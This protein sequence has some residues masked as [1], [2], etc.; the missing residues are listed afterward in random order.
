MEWSWAANDLAEKVTQEETPGAACVTAGSGAPAAEPNP[1][2][3]DEELVRLVAV[4]D[5]EAF[6]TLV[7][8][9]AQKWHGLAYRL[10]G[11]RDAAEDIVQDV[12]LRLWSQPDSF[13]PTF[14]QAPAPRQAGPD[15]LSRIIAMERDRALQS[16]IATLPERQRVALVLVY[17]TGLGAKE[18]ARVMDISLKAFEAL[19]VRAKR[20]LREIVAEGDGD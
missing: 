6:R 20:T 19:L 3:A 10:L 15:A 11:R 8:R 9:H 13:R 12:F 17:S 14:P 1:V 4:G 18:A 7:H 16:A 2:L 5:S